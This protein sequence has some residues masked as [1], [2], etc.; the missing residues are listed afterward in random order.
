MAL[1][2]LVLVVTAVPAGAAPSNGNSAVE[3]N[4]DCGEDGF[5][6]VLVQFDTSAAAAFGVES[7]G[8]EYVLSFLDFRGY[9]GPTELTS[10]DGAGEPFI[11]GAREWGKRNGFTRSFDCSGRYAQDLGDGT[12]FSSFFEVTLSAK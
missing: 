1:V 12:W 6:P 5:L 2:A 8:R 9:L 11:A 3:L 10:E 4:M 7:N